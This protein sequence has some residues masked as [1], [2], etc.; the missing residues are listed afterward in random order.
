MLVLASKT[1]TIP[2]ID[3]TQNVW[4]FLFQAYLVKNWNDKGMMLTQVDFS[5]NFNSVTDDIIAKI[6]MDI[7]WLKECLV[8]LNQFEIMVV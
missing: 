6:E 5:G 2:A 3:V 8:W 7:I 4:T 1:P